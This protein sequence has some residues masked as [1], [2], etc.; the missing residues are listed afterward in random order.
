M[1][2]CRVLV[3]EDDRDTREVLVD[4][5]HDEGYEARGAED[6]QEAKKL[7]E[8][9]EFRPDV[10]VLDLYMPGVNGHQFRAALQA[11]ARF[12]HIPVIL[13]SGT[14]PIAAASQAF[15]QLQKPLDIDA[16]L[17][18]VQRGCSARKKRDQALSA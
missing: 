14:T 3:V 4:L 10:I 2:D 12:A 1:I 18:V 9:A 7:L 17:A 6:C 8:S 5:L 16:L 13:C 11:D 15:A